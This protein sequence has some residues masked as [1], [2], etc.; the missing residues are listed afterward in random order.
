MATNGS[1]PA[2]QGIV[3]TNVCI[4]KIILLIIII[5]HIFDLSRGF[6]NYFLLIKQFVYFEYFGKIFFVTFGERSLYLIIDQ[7]NT[8]ILLIFK[9]ISHNVESLK[10]TGFLFVLLVLQNNFCSIRRNIRFLLLFMV[11]KELFLYKNCI[12][13]IFQVC[14]RFKKSQDF[15]CVYRSFPE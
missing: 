5:T 12:K 13:M 14:I 2:R 11:T 4:S 6:Y 8:S 9:P 10:Q 1:Q 15:T 3:Q 7:I